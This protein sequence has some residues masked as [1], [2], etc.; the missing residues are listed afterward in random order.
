[1]K[2]ILKWIL[3]LSIVVL[4][5]SGLVAAQKPAATFCGDLSSADCTLL[6]DAETINNNLDSHSFKLELK[7]DARGLPDKA[8]ENLSFDFTGSGSVSLG[9]KGLPDT[10]GLDATSFSKDPK[11][12]FD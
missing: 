4:A 7:I 1:M 9:R 3:L 8:F 10:S 12:I 6:T 2:H 11:A 5:T